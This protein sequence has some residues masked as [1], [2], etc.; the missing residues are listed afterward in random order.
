MTALGAIYQGILLLAI[1]GHMLLALLVFGFLFGA[2][3]SQVAV[4]A[5][6]LLR[7]SPSG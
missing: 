5:Y 4:G 1:W 3:I 2:F 7:K 6:R